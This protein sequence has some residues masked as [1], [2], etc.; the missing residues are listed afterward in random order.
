MSVVREG[1]M[2]IF[3]LETESYQ[4]LHCQTEKCRQLLYDLL[5]AGEDCILALDG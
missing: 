1:G 2:D 3:S 5:T 4:S